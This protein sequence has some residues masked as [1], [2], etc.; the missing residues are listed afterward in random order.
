[1]K[2]PDIFIFIFLLCFFIEFIAILLS[3][4]LK[5]KRYVEYLHTVFYFFRGISLGIIISMIVNYEGPLST[6]SWAVKNRYILPAIILTN[7][8]IGFT[9]VFLYFK[10]KNNQHL[11][12]IS[13]SVASGI[14]SGIFL[15]LSQLVSMK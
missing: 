3:D 9:S 10:S 11:F 13:G 6:L 12:Y 7:L 4:I 1:M 5:H 15:C 14:I 8:I 2:T